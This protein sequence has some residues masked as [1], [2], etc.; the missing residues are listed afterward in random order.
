MVFTTVESEFNGQ[1]C[2]CRGGGSSWG[3]QICVLD[4]V[5]PGVKGL[6]PGALQ[7]SDGPA[8]TL[9]LLLSSGELFFLNDTLGREGLKVRS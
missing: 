3:F 1:M 7:A 8:L 6:L 4:F 9:F 2:C 5:G